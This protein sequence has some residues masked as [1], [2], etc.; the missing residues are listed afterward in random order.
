MSRATNNR[1]TPSASRNAIETSADSPTQAAST[2]RRPS[3]SESRPAS[4]SATMTPTA[5]V[6][7]TSVVTIAPNP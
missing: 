4:S 5:Y 3:T 2:G 1:A 6:A 7:N